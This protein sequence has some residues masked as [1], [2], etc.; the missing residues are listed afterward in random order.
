V[1]IALI[2]PGAYTPPYDDR[3][4]S[5][6]GAR[7][8]DVA[9]LTAPFR[10]GD[11]PAPDGYRREELLFR[12]SASLFRGA[13]RS[14][15]RL[16][17]K[18]LEYVPGVRTLRRRIDELDPDVVHLQWL[19]HR[20]DLDLRWLRSIADRRRTVLTAHDLWAMLE[21][22]RGEWRRVFDVVDRV[23]VHSR[24]GLG[25]LLRIGLPADKVARI[26][27]AVF[28]P[29]GPAGAMPV[30]A[31]STLLFFGLVRG[32]KGIDLLLRA[33]PEIVRRVP[34][35]RLIVAGDEHDPVGPFRT[36]AA[37]LRIAD[38]VEW[39][40]TFQGEPEIDGL[41]A[42][43][44]LVVLPYRRRIDSS[45]VLASA[46]GRE[47]PVVV[48]DVGNLGETVEEFGAGKVVPP[49]DVDALAA[50]CIHLLTDDEARARAIAG[51]RAARAALTWGR[52]AELHERLY[53]GIAAA[54]PGA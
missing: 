51:A 53:E 25:E 18:A 30:A 49:E 41:M 21:G 14:P 20:P 16:P 40:P 11:A 5:S 43:A 37:E 32:Y 36:L 39:R 28:D 9:L 46:L 34:E 12:L 19:V 33:L 42:T 23:V 2:D 6:L 24:R 8:H 35:A 17:V 1:R 54:A 44:A 52:A 26:P 4:A 29:G 47:R 45:G 15:L 50:A 38:R 31:G 7:G 22:R 3:L 13:P 48:S 27:H 10:F